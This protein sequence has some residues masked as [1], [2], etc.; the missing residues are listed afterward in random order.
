MSKSA[1]AP[2]I[3]KSRI[4]YD[5]CPLCESEKMEIVKQGDCS[6]HPL[7]NSIISSYIAWKKCLSCHHIFTEGYFT[8]EASSVIFG[9]TNEHQKVGADYERQ[10]P[11]SARMIEKVLPFVQDG[12]WLDIGFGN[13][14]LLFTA[15]EH[16]FTPVGIDLRAEN[17]DLMK[18]LGIEAHCIDL[19]KF[20]SSAEFSV[21]SM[22]DVLEH[23]AYPKE[24]LKSVHNL[25]A[26][27]GVIFVSMPNADSLIWD[28]L[29][30][31]NVNPYWGELEHFHNFGRERLY[32]LLEETGFEPARYGVSERYRACMEVIAKKAPPHK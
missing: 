4:L 20:E 14:S 10:R 23:V 15:K 11:I 13:G 5:A 24:F 12:K 17:V 22:A 2:K 32:K 16:G 7:Y 31:G 21:I 8:D 30:R 25:L 1:K 3:V 27:S 9:K 29:D 19:L 28:L 6:K 18:K 26:A